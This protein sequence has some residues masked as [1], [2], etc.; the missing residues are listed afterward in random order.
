VLSAGNPYRLDKAVLFACMVVFSIGQTILFALMGLAGREIGLREIEVGAVV[1][2]SAVVMTFMA[3]WWGKRVDRWGRKRL[4]V[5]GMLGYGLGTLLFAGVLWLGMTG[6]LVAGAFASLICARVLYAMMIGSLHP[7]S[8]AYMAN[9]TSR[10]DRSAGMALL[11]AGFALGSIL[12]PGLAAVAVV[13]GLLAPLAIAAG[14]AVACAIAAAL[15]LREHRPAEHGAGSAAQVSWRSMAPFLA[16][17]F[18]VWTSISAIQQTVSF[19]VQDEFAPDAREAATLAGFAFMALAI[20]TIAMQAGVVQRFKPAPRT[21]LSLGFPLA[22]AGVA[23]LAV[24]PS[25]PAMIVA[26]ALMGAGY[27]FVHPGASAAVSLAVGPQAQGMAAGRMG[28]A[29]SAGYIAGPLS[30]TAVYAL[31][32]YAPAILGAACTLVAAL[33]FVFVI[34]P[35]LRR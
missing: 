21:M 10:A 11:G 32:P 6:W 14:L 16:Q 18:L 15:V 19:F 35:S 2:S 22:L 9:I 12:G 17:S 30:G 29:A 1:A 5:G 34:R 4:V 28:G 7:A 23:L 24:T 27:A 33:I 31:S 25:Y 20:A 26:F 8:G 3:P 13:L